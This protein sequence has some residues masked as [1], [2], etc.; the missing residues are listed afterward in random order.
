MI[1]SKMHN[2]PP[3]IRS[4]NERPFWTVKDSPSV[5]EGAKT[6]RSPAHPVSRLS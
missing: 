2:V 6:C 1:C 4:R 5:T 3:I